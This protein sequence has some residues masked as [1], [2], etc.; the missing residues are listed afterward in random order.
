ML[1]LLFNFIKGIGV[2]SGTI[3]LIILIIWIILILRSDTNA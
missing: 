2:V 3:S 1:D